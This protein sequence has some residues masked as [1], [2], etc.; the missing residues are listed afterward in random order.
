MLI[1]SALLAH[2]S[3]GLAAL[4]GAV[5]SASYMLN[6]IRISFWGPIR[7]DS[8]KLQDLSVRELLVLTVP[9]LLV[10][11]LGFAPGYFLQ[12]NDKVADTWLLTILEPP[13]IKNNEVADSVNFAK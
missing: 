2:P 10:V 3:L 6:F 9:A 8:L 12:V 5:L 13:I 7:Y 11:F 4:A 1:F